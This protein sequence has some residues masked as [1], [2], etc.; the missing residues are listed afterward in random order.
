M[1]I[2]WF[3]SPRS[4]PFCFPTS[5]SQQ[6][7]TVVHNF[8]LMCSLQGFILP[9]H[10]FFALM[11]YI[12]YFIYLWLQWVFV[13]AWAFSSFCKQVLPFIAVQGLIIVVA[14]LVLKHRL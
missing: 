5:Y 4:S 10:D 1:S 9:L 6:S 7:S 11:F 13:A 12:H 14:S 3:G 8:L 2:S